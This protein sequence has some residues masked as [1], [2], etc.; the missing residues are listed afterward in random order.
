MPKFK[1]LSIIFY[2]IAI[3]M[4][5]ASLTCAASVNNLGNLH[6]AASYT[7]FYKTIGMYGEEQDVTDITLPKLEKTIPIVAN[8]LN[9]IRGED[10]D[11]SYRAVLQ[12]DYFSVFLNDKTTR[13]GTNLVASSSI[14]NNGEIAS[15]FLDTPKDSK[16]I[17]DW[18]QLVHSERG[19]PIRDSLRVINISVQCARVNSQSL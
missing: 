17:T 1:S 4:I 8:A 13:L 10:G 6:C 9:T 12:D 19:Y 5:S 2:F 16:V 11:V 18:S 7:V 3:T 14:L 15:I